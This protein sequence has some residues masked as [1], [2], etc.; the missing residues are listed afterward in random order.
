MT[1]IQIYEHAGTTPFIIKLHKRARTVWERLE[2]LEY[3]P[4]V[5]LKENAE[6]LFIIDK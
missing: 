5:K 6:I 1:T 4:L 3:Q 2:T